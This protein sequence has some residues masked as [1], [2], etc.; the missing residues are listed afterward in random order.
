[1]MQACHIDFSLVLSAKYNIWIDATWKEINYFVTVGIYVITKL[2]LLTN[3]IIT[4]YI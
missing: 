3:I 1:M 4:P 2:I